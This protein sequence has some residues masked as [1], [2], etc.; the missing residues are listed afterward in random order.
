MELALMIGKFAVE[1]G[2]D[3]VKQIASACKADEITVEMWEE[4]ANRWLEKNPDDYL[5]EAQERAKK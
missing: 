5:R 4:Q 2:Y 3:A 1:H